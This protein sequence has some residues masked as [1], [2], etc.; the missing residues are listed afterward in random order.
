MN[1]NEEFATVC[2][3]L[4]AEGAVARPV[5]FYVFTEDDTAL[6]ECMLRIAFAIG[7]HGLNRAKCAAFGGLGRD[8][9]ECGS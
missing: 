1:E 9:A 6:G 3:Q 4:N 7:M 2:L 5:L 8:F